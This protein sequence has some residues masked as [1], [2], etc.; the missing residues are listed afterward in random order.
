MNAAPTPTQRSA[1]P[2]RKRIVHVGIAAPAEQPGGLNRYVDDLAAAQSATH[3][4]RA[5]VLGTRASRPFYRF[6]GRLDQPLPRRLL[7]FVAAGMRSQPVDVAHL[8]FALT[9]AAFLVGRRLA[10][11]QDGAVVVH[12]HGPWAAESLASGA[13]GLSIRVKAVVERWLYARAGRLIVLS[14][15]FK[16][17]LHER[18]GV[19]EDRIVVVPPGV[20]LTRFTPGDR[21]AARQRLGLPGDV[22][23]V[24]CARRLVARMGI[25]DAAEALAAASPTAHLVV[26]GDGPERSGLQRAADAVLPDRNRFLGRVDEG[27]LL[28]VYRAADATVIPTLELE[29]FGLVCLESMAV[30]TPAV[31]R[32]QGGL[33]EALA[34]FAGGRLL[35]TS[36]TIDA[37]RA[38]LAQVLD[39]PPDPGGCRSYAEQFSWSRAVERID[40]VYADAQGASPA[41]R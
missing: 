18:Y 14:V 37:L 4:V 17:L 10:R 25:G 33:V 2:R 3:D 41:T 12:F 28:D 19:P 5:L 16:D 11:K 39:G 13:R 35:A 36:M 27:T 40:A 9:G 24:A 34:G 38:A 30:D 1:H 22:P 23:I 8:H 15:V 7:G 20:D 6:V 26:V 29:G 31:A 21:A 32:P